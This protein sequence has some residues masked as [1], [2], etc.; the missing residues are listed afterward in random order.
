VAKIEKLPI[1]NRD[2][3]IKLEA[4]RDFEDNDGTKRVAGEEWIENGPMIFTPKIEVRIVANIEPI[5]ISSNQALKV[6]AI[7]TTKDNNGK[8][9]C[10]GEEWLIRELGFYIPRIDETV[11]QLV[12]GEIINEK[13]ALFLQAN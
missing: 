12:E 13:T 2:C 8:E 5:T 11:I 3:A 9:R 4:L 6:R 7:R 10:A 1:V